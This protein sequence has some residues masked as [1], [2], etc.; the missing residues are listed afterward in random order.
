MWAL[1]LIETTSC[2]GTM[3]SVQVYLD[4]LSLEVGLQLLVL[5]LVA[6][7]LGA[8]SLLETRTAPTALP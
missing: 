2:A 5:L 8:Q 3:G 4:I 7:K 1:H 6:G